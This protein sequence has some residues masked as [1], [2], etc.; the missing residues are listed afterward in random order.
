M[1]MRLF[2]FF[3]LLPLSFFAQSGAERLTPLERSLEQRGLIDVRAAVPGVYVSLMYARPDNFVGRVLYTDLHHA[4]L[5]PETARAL[6]K[7]QNALQQK[8]PDYALKVYDATRPMRIQ[9]RMWNVVAHTSKNI[10]VSNPAHGGGLHNYGL[11]V[12][13]TLCW[14]RDV[15]DRAGRLLHAAGDTTGLSMGT[16]IDYLGPAA[17]VRD[18]THW[19]RRGV[20]RP[21]H[22]RLR[23]VLR[24]AMS[25]GGFRVLPTEWWHF[26]FKTRAQARAHY[27]PIP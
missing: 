22:V 18:E 26:N 4:Y 12:D 10:Y 20:L 14:A 8:H 1:N 17:H 25:A 2:L 6:R 16:P 27:T 21:E 9:Q 11:A 13:L 23:R 19:L 5:L 15:R 3:F 24:E 7:A